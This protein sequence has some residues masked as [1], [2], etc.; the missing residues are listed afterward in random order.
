MALQWHWDKKCGEATFRTPT[1]KTKK[2]YRDYKV[3]LYEGNAY[4]IF[5]YEYKENEKD[6]Y[7]LK[8]FFADKAHMRRCLGLDRQYKQTYGDNS[9]DR[10]YDR[11]IKIRFNKK[12][13]RNYMEIITALVQAFDNI[14]IDVYSEEVK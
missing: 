7:N 12:K 6:M 1:D 8:G 9:Y 4:L 14:E 5:I 10:E 2:G 13:C 3:S 11:L